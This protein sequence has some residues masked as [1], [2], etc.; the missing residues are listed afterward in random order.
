MK[1]DI[2]SLQKSPSVKMRNELNSM[3]LR[4]WTSEEMN[5]F[6]AIIAA[7][8]NKGTKLLKFD[9]DQ[10]RDIIDFSQH[11]LERWE[12]TMFNCSQKISKLTYVEKSSKKVKIMTLFSHFEL[13]FENRTVEVKVSENYEYILNEF[14]AQFTQFELQEFTK[15]SS[16]YAKTAYRYFKQWKKVGKLEFDVEEF[17]TIFD[18]PLSFKACHIKDRVLKPIE[19]ELSPFFK[20]IQIETVK[21]KKRGRPILKYIFTWK[22]EKT[23]EWV[24]NK[25][26]K[27]DYYK[28]KKSNVPE[29]A[30]KTFKTQ[31]TP[32]DK[33]RLEKIKKEMFDDD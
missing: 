8:K 20:N 15:I 6:F 7:S 4:R 10:I 30:E 16:T 25:Y 31:I 24:E 14:K 2:I 5:F 33:L 26:K 19:K 17:R 27:N 21:S 28:P 12:K 29:W 18:I 3:S 22:P 13:D 32:E 1:N 9:S 11:G 23:E